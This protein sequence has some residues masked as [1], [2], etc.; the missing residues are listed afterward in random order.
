MKPLPCPVCWAP[1]WALVD[2]GSS[3]RPGSKLLHKKGIKVCD[4]VVCSSAQRL[5]LDR[6][7][8]VTEDWILF[9]RQP[10]TQSLWNQDT[11]GTPSYSPILDRGQSGAR[12]LTVQ[13][14]DP[15]LP[16]RIVIAIHKSGILLRASRS[17]FGWSTQSLGLPRSWMV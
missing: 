1:L 16:G 3:A 2:S 5:R 14:I 12:K 15:L 9:L 7:P 8:G 13:L 11:L 17:S 4:P 6:I 10:R